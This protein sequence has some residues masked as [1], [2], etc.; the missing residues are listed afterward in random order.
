[1]KRLRLTITGATGVMLAVM[2]LAITGAGGAA[3]AKDRNKT[4]KKDKAVRAESGSR[5]YI[6]IY[7]QELTDE[8]KAGL[9]L[10]GVSKGVLVSGVEEDGP[11]D[12]GGIEDGDVVVSFN[13]KSVATPDELRDMVRAADPGSRA[14]IEIVREGKKQ[15]V[16]VTLGEREKFL[17]A[18]HRDFDIDG[19]DLARVF[20]LVGGPRL[21][22]RAHEIE[23]DDMA[24]YF[25]V[26]PGEGLLVLGVD[27]DS[28]AG[29]AGVKPGDVLQ[30]IDGEKVSSVEDIRDACRDMDEGE[31]FT[32]GVIRHGKSETI[33]VIMDEPRPAWA[34]NEFNGDWQGW[35][36]HAPRPLVVPPHA[37]RELREE[38]DQLRKEVEQLR[39]QLE[40]KD[41]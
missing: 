5:G 32:V 19:P 40:K 29:K 22:I 25:G 8:V 24:S 14:K 11:A 12:E 15:T 3:V 36:R 28:A 39:Q 37:G 2:L 33:K 18:R 13:G 23:S 27:D 9:D 35:R 26:K 20:A 38:L 1:M 31:E 41:G 34:F 6:G 17:F 7:M 10:K 4:D 21:G 16:E 30:T